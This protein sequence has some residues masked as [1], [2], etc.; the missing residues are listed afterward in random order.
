MTLYPRQAP[1]ELTFLGLR[2]MISLYNSST[3]LSRSPVNP[4]APVELLKAWPGF[5]PKEDRRSR[6]AR[7]SPSQDLG[8]WP[9]DMYDT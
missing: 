8:T 7:G 4:K 5:L 6:K 1:E 9:W 2:T 3:R